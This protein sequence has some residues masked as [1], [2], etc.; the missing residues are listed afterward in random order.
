MQAKIKDSTHIRAGKLNTFS[1]MYKTYGAKSF[2]G[3][4]KVANLFFQVVFYSL[5]FGVNDK[6]AK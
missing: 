4:E 2:Y 3:Q 6:L 1:F 5:Y